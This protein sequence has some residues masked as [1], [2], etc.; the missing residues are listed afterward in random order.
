MPLLHG[1]WSSLLSGRPRNRLIHFYTFKGTSPP[2]PPPKEIKY[3]LSTRA[4][5]NEDDQLK[6]MYS[7]WS[8]YYHSYRLSLEFDLHSYSSPA[9]N[10]S[11]QLLKMEKR[12]TYNTV[13]CVH[14]QWG[15]NKIKEPNP[16]FEK[17][18]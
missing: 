2:S 7:R 3:K 10:Y 5:H 16:V 6:F 8:K 14:C 12:Y 13:D 17:R 15:L 11:R 9:H 4:G 18:T 1:K